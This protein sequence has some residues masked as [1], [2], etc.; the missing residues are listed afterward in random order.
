MTVTV[1]AITPDRVLDDAIAALNKPGATLPLEEVDRALT[2]APYDG[3]LWHVKGLIHREHNHRDLAIPALLR[4]IELAP[5]EPLIAHGYARTLQEAGLPSVDAFARALKLSPDKGAIVEGF[6]NAL[7]HERRFAEAIA[8]LETVLRRNP[9][10]VA[11]HTLLSKIRWT[12]GD[13]QAFTRS[14]DAVL[15]RYP[16]ALDLRREQI[17]ALIY[18]EQWQEVLRRIEEGRRAVGDNIL[19]DINEAVVQAE[20]GETDLADAL[21]APFAHLDDA[22]V[23]V[24]FV[25]HLLRSGRPEMA[26]EAVEARLGKQD[27]F[28][29]WPYASLSWRLTGDKRWEWLEGDPRFV[30]VYD[31]A[32]R[33]PPLD[34]LA[35]TLHRLHTYS[36]HP[37]EQSLRGG[38]Q[39]EGDIFQHVDPV[40]VEL[41]EAVRETV[42]EHVALLPANDQSHPLLSKRRDSIRFKGAWSVRLQTQGY[43]A[44]HVHPAGWISSALYVVLPPDLGRDE[45]GFLTLGDSSAP[46]FKVD[47][48]TLRSIEPKPGRLI[49]FPSY[50]WHGTRPFA[51]GERMTVAFDVAKPA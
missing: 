15:A 49:L 19:F 8:G 25:R 23:Q 7:L 10:W 41:R 38:T 47:L 13:R 26:A 3:R 6:V 12:E 39:T 34:R 28:L 5:T 9:L 16:A 22:T 21:F 51:A 14:F 20:L 27:A 36:G 4:A 50:M 43:H 42:R 40:L 31:I 35:E 29:F 46:T 1:R 33:L 24:R 45:A 32:D 17:I 48:P 18:A 11:G 37:L 30:G 2:Q 44:N